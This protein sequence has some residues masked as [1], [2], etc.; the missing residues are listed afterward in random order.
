M[1][2]TTDSNRVKR[3][4]NIIKLI[5]AAF[6][7]IIFGGFTIIFTIQQ[8]HVSNENRKQDQ[9]QADE[10]NIRKTFE[11]YIDHVSILLVDHKFN[12]SNPEHLLYLRVKTLTALRHVDVNRKRDIILFL[13]ESRL[14]RNAPY[15]LDYIY[16]PGIYA[17]NI[18]F[19][20]CSLKYAV[21]DHASMS[22]AQILNSTISYSSFYQINAPNAIIGDIIFHRNNFSN[23]ILIGTHFSGIIGWK[24][25]VFLT[26]ADLFVS[27]TF[28]ESA[29]NFHNYDI[30]S[31][32]FQNLRFPD[33]SFRSI[34]SSNL[35]VDGGAEGCQ[36]NKSQE[37]WLPRNNLTRMQISSYNITNLTITE[38][39]NNGD[40]AFFAHAPGESS[41][42]Q[43]ID[44]QRFSVLIRSE[45]A[46]CNISAYIGCVEKGWSNISIHISYL[47]DNNI[48]INQHEIFSTTLLPK[49]VNFQTKA[50]PKQTRMLEIQLISNVAGPL[51]FC[52]I[53]DIEMNIFHTSK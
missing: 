13:H 14:I 19:S 47:Q 9:L 32:N 17:P 20:W 1:S 7:S 5:L 3:C 16:L 4:L 34:D 48:Q 29:L 45:Q 24:E 46:A 37:I 25:G 36:S 28:E 8:N 53:D 43:L 10:L 39:T 27:Y 38:S 26:N 35:I 6:P 18:V 52:L 33:G 2:E 41:L 11:T 23:A 49:K 40:C 50:I 12:R 21:F 42:I 31:L 30:N 44:V 22:N 15:Q 51:S